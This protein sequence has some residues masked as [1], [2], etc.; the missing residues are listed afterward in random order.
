M[1][2]ALIALVTVGFVVA[3]ISVAKAHSGDDEPSAK[4][5]DVSRKLDREVT[6][7]QTK[8]Q[9]E[10]VLKAQDE[11]KNDVD[12]FAANARSHTLI[13][14]VREELP[15]AV[16]VVGKVDGKP[17]CV[18]PSKDAPTMI[19]VFAAGIPDAELTSKVAPLEAELLRSGACEASLE[20]FVPQMERY[21]IAVAGPGG[22]KFGRTPV[23]KDGQPQT[24]ALV[25]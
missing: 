12:E 6:K 5:V 3:A 4:S 16:W 14:T 22:G 2:R 19:K 17:A 9:A 8:Q 25:G 11:L 1:K 13:V 24:V 15:G 18:T 10:Q 7:E 23:R 20:L 21:E